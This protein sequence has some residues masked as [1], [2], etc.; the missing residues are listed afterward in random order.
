MLEARLDA[1][2]FELSKLEGREVEVDAPFNRY[3]TCHYSG[4]KKGARKFLF[5]EEKRDVICKIQPFPRG[6]PKFP[7]VRPK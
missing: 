1:M 5:A 3:F 6:I 2:A 4:E 7:W